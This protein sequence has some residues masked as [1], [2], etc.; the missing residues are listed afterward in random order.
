M[1]A[2]TVARRRS[3]SSE[4]VREAQ[5]IADRKSYPNAVDINNGRRFTGIKMRRFPVAALL[6]VDIDIK[7]MH[8]VIARHLFAVGIEYQTGGKNP[9]GIG[10]VGN[11][12]RT[13]DIP[14]AMPARLLR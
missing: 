12:N 13:S 8:L 9:L 4:T 11:R 10:T 2:Q 6:V 7:Q 5:V 3:T 1:A 14:Q